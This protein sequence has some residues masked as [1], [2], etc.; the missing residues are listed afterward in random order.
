[1]GKVYDA[2][3][4]AWEDADGGLLCHFASVG[5]WSKWGSW[6]LLQYAD[7]DPKASPKYQAVMRWRSGLARSR[8]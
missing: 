2:Y 5:T 8:H 4:K 6:G 1:M 7:D 3:F